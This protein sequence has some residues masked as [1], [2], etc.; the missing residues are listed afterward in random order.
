MVRWPERLRALKLAAAAWVTLAASAPSALAARFADPVVTVTGGA[1]AGRR[2]PDRL[3]FRGIP[4]AAPPLGPLRWRPP[5]PAR[6]P[7]TRRAVDPAPACLQGDYGWNHADHVFADEDCLTLDLATPALTGRRPVLVWIHGGSNHAG[8]PGDTVLSSL[9]GQGIVV[10]AVRYRLGT[11]G[12]LAPREGGASGGNY[13]LMDQIAALRW[14][15]PNIARFGGDPDQVTIGGESAGAQDVGLLL[16]APAAR[17]LFA[18]AIMESG[19]PTFGLPYR[20][21][22]EARRIGDQLTGLLG[23]IDPR[24]ASPAALI[25]ADAKLHDGALPHDDF[26]WLRA[27]V[28]GA[29][30]PRAPDALLADAP[31]KAM[32]IGTNAVELDLWGGRPY[33]DAFL[34]V[35]YGANADAAR[36]P[37]ASPAATTRH[38]ILGSARSTSASPP[39]PPSPAPP[40]GWRRR[41][42]RREHRFIATSSTAHPATAAPVTRAS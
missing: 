38:P 32:L 42:P 28:D 40:T 17:D 26:L 35:S 4:F 13:G 27:T 15:R 18:R 23:G 10:V 9:V 34:A 41:G 3:V 8:S 21:L 25:A 39:T 31:A 20:T 22:V 5:Q 30:L 36:R 6:W 1:V 19:T 7:G 14:V 33:R 37:M 12:F 2:L 29:V 11:L 24:R 16:A